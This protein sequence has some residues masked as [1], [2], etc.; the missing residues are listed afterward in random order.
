MHEH[1][2]DTDPARIVIDK[3]TCRSSYM[4]EDSFGAGLID[5]GVDT[6]LIHVI[7][8]SS[9]AYIARVYDFDC[10]I[11]ISVKHNFLLR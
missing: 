1:N 7:T 11:M 6:Y 9:V 10:G 8:V 3:D 4:F 5:S 2:G